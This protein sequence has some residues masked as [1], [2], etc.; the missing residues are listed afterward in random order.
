MKG[1][2]TE[3]YRV[4]LDFENLLLSLSS[5]YFVCI[6]DLFSPWIFHTTYNTV[7][8]N[9]IGVISTTTAMDTLTAIVLLI[10]FISFMTFVAFFGRLPALR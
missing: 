5:F 8:D 9:E 7:Q 3:E 6:V 1:L 4:G 2:G 10:L